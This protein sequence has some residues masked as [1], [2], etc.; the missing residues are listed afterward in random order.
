MIK[1]AIGLGKTPEE[2]LADAKAKL[3]APETADVKFETLELPTKKTLGIFGKEKPAKVKAFYEAPDEPAA[4]SSK[5]VGTR[6][7]PA[8]KSA[9]KSAS[10]VSAAGFEKSE[11][12]IR[13]ILKGMGITDCSVIFREEDEGVS[14]DLDCG[15]SY[16]V[17]IG[18]R[19]ETLDAI[20]YLVRLF[21]NRGKENYK[22]VSI[23]IGNYRE[24]REQTLQELAK[25]SAAKVLKY[26]RNTVLDPMNPYE[27][28][29]IHTTIQEIEGVE[30]HSVGSESE[31]KVVITLAD[32]VKPTNPDSRG[33]YNNNNRGGGYN[34]NNRGGNRGGGYNNNRGSGYNNDRKPQQQSSAPQRSPRSDLT[35]T[36]RYGK[37]EPKNKP[38]E[39]DSAE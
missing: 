22:R 16:G 11:A 6:S 9:A 5:P 32:G 4:A 18:R 19:G 34:N 17:V 26:G 14:I 25:K 13:A 28:R 12:Y 15:E 30:S 23:N 35:G 27:R 8:K 38:A 7:E 1:E 24:K 33:H 20:Q 31:R 39:T 10:V 3:N 36:T 21:M 37:I 2:A 29:I